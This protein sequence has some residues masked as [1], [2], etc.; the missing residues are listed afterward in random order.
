MDANLKND[1]SCRCRFPSFARFSLRGRVGV[2]R[3]AESAGFGFRVPCFGFAFERT[4]RG[5]CF[6]FEAPVGPWPPLCLAFRVLET[7]ASET[8]FF[9]F[10]LAALAAT[11][12][13]DVRSPHE[14]GKG[15]FA[16][17][18][19]GFSRAS[20]FFGAMA[21]GFC[22]SRFLDCFEA[23]PSSRSLF[24]RPSLLSLNDASALPTFRLPEKSAGASF[25]A[26]SLALFTA[27]GAG[28]LRCSCIIPS[29]GPDCPAASWRASVFAG[30]AAPGR[31]RAA[32][33]GRR[34][35]PAGR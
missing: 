29:R 12:A 8:A 9:L 28:F 15:R 23:S 33:P 30:R 34:P 22:A 20:L 3:L 31:P 24:I 5:G 35:P 21:F 26:R 32:A 2:G 7:S 19:L 25:P 11:E 10:S 13:F 1:C 27:A 14:A 16:F 6:L 4:A 17:F 18:T